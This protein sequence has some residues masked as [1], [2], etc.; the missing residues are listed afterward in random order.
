VQI[1]RQESYVKVR[2]SC[3]EFPDAAV[4]AQLSIVKRCY[5]NARSSWDSGQNSGQDKVKMV[6]RTIFKLKLSE[7]NVGMLKFLHE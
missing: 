3:M 2:R 6:D 4:P 7:C 1:F 5:G